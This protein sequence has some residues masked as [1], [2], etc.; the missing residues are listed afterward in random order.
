MER[1]S[2]ERPESNLMKQY[3]EIV[4]ALIIAAI[5]SLCW[6]AVVDASESNKVMKECLV[7]AGYKGDVTNFDNFGKASKCFHD[8][9]KGEMNKEYLK[10]K[11]FMEENP[12]Y[13]GG[14]WDWE[15]KE[16]AGYDCVKYHETGVKI[17][18][19]PIFR[20]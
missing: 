6:V 12:W 16:R 9:K 17:C 15:T 20:N 4:I 11:F 7:T 8:W 5:L 1:T 2:Q 19:K 10:L 13:K 18:R 14:N 3:S